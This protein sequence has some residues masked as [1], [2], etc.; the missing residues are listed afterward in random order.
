[1]NANLVTTKN[2]SNPASEALYKNHWPS[3][4]E[5]YKKYSED[6]EQCGGCSFFAPF[7]SDWGL[8][9]HSRSRHFTETVF[10]HFTCP[11]F[12]NEGWG[13]HS[14]SENPDD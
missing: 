14:F 9:C 11:V 3:E 6:C 7:N 10:E 5:L 8:C 13:M 12:V 4:P 2:W 1:M